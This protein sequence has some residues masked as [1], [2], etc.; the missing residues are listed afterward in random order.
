MF[1]FHM[2]Q[3]LYVVILKPQRK[4]SVMVSI[5]DFSSSNSSNEYM[6]TFLP[7]IGKERSVLILT[8]NLD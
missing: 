1:L 4:F 6:H 7:G 5:S 8:L 2:L 3:P